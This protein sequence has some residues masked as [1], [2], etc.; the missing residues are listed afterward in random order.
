MMSML[1]LTFVIQPWP[2][3]DFGILVDSQTFADEENGIQ[4]KIF[5]LYTKAIFGKNIVRNSNYTP[6]VGD[7]TFY[8]GKHYMVLS[9]D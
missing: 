3:Q 2:P 4:S 5:M 6:K 9:R 7:G 8:N 1:L